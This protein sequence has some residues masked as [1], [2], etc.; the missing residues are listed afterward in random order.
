MGTT[1]A[2]PAPDPG[3][4]R[5]RK[6]T[7]VTP[8]FAGAS[9]TPLD[10]LFILF[11]SVFLL[12]LLLWILYGDR[13][14]HLPG[15]VED[16][17]KGIWSKVIV[18]A[19]AAGTL[20]LRKWLYK[21]T[22]SPNYLLWIPGITILLI[23]TLFLVK[24]VMPAP[25]PTPTTASTHY[26]LPIRFSAEPLQADNALNTSDAR[27]IS[28]RPQDAK[29]PIYIPLD[30]PEELGLYSYDDVN[31]PD[32]G[33]FKAEIIHRAIL[34]HL[35]NTA[36]DSREYLLCIKNN[37]KKPFPS[38]FSSDS[39]KPMLKLACS[40]DP[41]TGEKRC[42]SVDQGPGYLM[43]CDD[44]AENRGLLPVVYAAS[45]E[46]AREPRWVV[47]SLDTL[48]KMTDRE[49]VGYT[50]FYVSFT[51][52]GQ[53]ASADQ[54]YYVVRVNDKTIFIDGFSPEKF[55]YPLQK[56]TTNW[57]SFGLENLN[58]T[59][60]YEGF[61]KLQLTI[62]FLNGESEVYRQELQ[63][64]YV[65]LRDAPEVTIDSPIGAFH[66]NGKYVVPKNE[67]KYEVLLASANCGDPV[68]RE[69]I[70]RTM[71]AKVHF[72]QG[73]LK[74]NDKPIVMVV[75]PPLR[76]PPSYG[77]ALGQIQPTSQVQFTFS[78]DEAKRLC[79]WALEQRGKSAAGNLIQSNLRIYEV[80]TKGY[81]PCN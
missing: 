4:S 70:D 3:A 9:P 24:Q 72:D 7:S 61:E 45:A 35:V 2:A 36:L 79:H 64:N 29:R 55:I 77:L 42:L 11:A 37:P 67:D 66:W 40:K 80:A 14:G 69:C 21:S 30:K 33:E 56:G 78:E 25:P 60:Q 6:Q 47:P 28:F 22:P 17:V 48:D 59:G 68:Q 53:A 32:S 65:A 39:T 50:R 41:K 12:L 54:Y 18:G 1:G 71:N 52:A 74:F 49:R 26:H 15:W 31:V 51:P 81:S 34:S 10:T 62:V 75:R 58:F 43:S 20:A 8:G 46:Q 13:Y 27:E 73:G 38:S 5:K 16:S 23:G 57:I 19:G 63:R 76:I 44:I